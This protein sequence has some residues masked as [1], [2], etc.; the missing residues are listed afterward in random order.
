MYKRNTVSIL[1][2]LVVLIMLSIVNVF[3]KI[4]MIPAL[5]IVIQMEINL[6]TIS[7]VFIGFAFTSLGILLGMSS[8]KLI[9]RIKDTSIVMSKVLKIARSIVFL[10]VSVMISLY[11]VLGINR[12][13]F[14]EE[15]TLG[16]VDQSIYVIGLGSLVIGVIF[17]ALSIYELYDLIKR[18]YEYSIDKNVVESNTIAMEQYGKAKEKL[19]SAKF[20]K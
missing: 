5:D 8:E 9:Q 16:M 1:I 7:T 12:F 14:K 3:Y 19:K 13:L 11:F 15:S 20:E 10:L 17:Y 18:T 2:W 4:I 6:I